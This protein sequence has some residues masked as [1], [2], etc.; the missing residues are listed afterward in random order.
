M[1][2]SSKLG[3]NIHMRRF[4]FFF[5]L[6]LEKR[7]GRIVGLGGSLCMNAWSLQ[8]TWCPSLGQTLMEDHHV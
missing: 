4:F 7:K 1:L 6:L 2:G 5:L 8:G 3:E